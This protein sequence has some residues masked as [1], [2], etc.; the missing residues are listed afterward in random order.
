MGHSRFNSLFTNSR[1]RPDWDPNT[2]EYKTGS[3]VKRRGDSITDDRFW[4]AK[5]DH[6]SSIGVPPES[7]AGA[8][9]WEEDFKIDDFTD[10]NG[11]EEFHLAQWTRSP[12]DWITNLARPTVSGNLLE[13]ANPVAPNDSGY[14]GYCVDWN[15]VRGNYDRSTFTN[16]DHISIKW[17]QE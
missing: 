10:I 9:L 13:G 8:I 12:L 17:N 14:V 1:F 15:F 6:F 2:F 4:R 16:F 7:V 11:D 3:Q 5:I